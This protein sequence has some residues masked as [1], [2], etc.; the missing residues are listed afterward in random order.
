MSEKVYPQ[1]WIVV[2][3]KVRGEESKRGK[4]VACLM[5][6]HAAR[7]RAR[8]MAADDSMKAYHVWAMPNEAY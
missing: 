7:Q 4:I 6:E 5:T 2:I 1:D 3:R 8:D